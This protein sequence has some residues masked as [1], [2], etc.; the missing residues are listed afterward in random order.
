MACTAGLWFVVPDP[1]AVPLALALVVVASVGAELGNVFY[2]AMLPDLA[3]RDHYG[4]WSGWG[5][6]I[7]YAGG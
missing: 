3:D 5:W 2:N 1:A 6:G 7:G 4:R